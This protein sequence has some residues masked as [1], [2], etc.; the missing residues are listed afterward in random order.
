M[1]P[2]L[3]YLTVVMFAAQAE[4]DMADAITKQ[5]IAENDRDRLL[6]ELRY[7]LMC[8]RF[9]VM[10]FHARPVNIDNCNAIRF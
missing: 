7:E 1:G 6:L 8:F 4:N 3:R 9:E 5:T 10:V 2:Q